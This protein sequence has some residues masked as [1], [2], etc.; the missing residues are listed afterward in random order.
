MAFVNY[1]LN[2]Y[3]NLSRRIQSEHYNQEVLSPIH[4]NQTGMTPLQLTANNRCLLEA[5][6]ISNS[7][8]LED[9]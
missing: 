7:T 4:N 5:Q 8:L 2:L 1:F 9:D 3:H 6:I